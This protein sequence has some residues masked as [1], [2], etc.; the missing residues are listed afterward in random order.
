MTDWIGEAFTSDVGPSLHEEL[1]DIGNRL[2]GSEGERRGAER[3][4]EALETA[5]AREARLEAFDIQGWT[6]GSSAVA[7][8]DETFDCIALPR[9]PPGEV[10]GDLVDLGY[11][12]PEDFEAADVEGRVVVVDSN[13]PDW[14]DRFIHRREKYYYAVEG[15]ASAFLFRNHVE[16]CLAPTGSV[17]TEDAPIGDVPAVG[18][19]KEAGARLARRYEGEPVTVSVEADVH[20]A[21]SRNVHAVLGPDT[22]EEVLV[23]SHVDGHDIAEGA[24]DNGAGTAIVVQTAVALA[25]REDDLD[26][27]VHFV[28]FGSEEVGLDG[29]THYVETHDLDRVKAV[30]NNDGSGRAR[31]LRVVS[32]HF[33]ELG[34]AAERVADRLDNPVDV[35]PRLGPHSDHWP[36]VQRGVPGVQIR[37]VTGSRGRGWG[38]T[39]ADTYDKVDRRDVRTQAILVADL[40]VDVAREDVEVPRKEESEIARR[41]EEEDLAVGMK[42]IGDWPY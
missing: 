30:L 10:E 6:R 3:T 32:H 11:G 15:G 37:S 13:V 19:S 34:A 14:F 31:D 26:T 25:A 38:H 36:F 18:V 17:G 35:V 20:D 4:R 23:T 24:L 40:A 33:D 8:G 21:T 9:S 39:A 12:L 28:A 1:V 2:G 7:A 41:L 22:D 5:G 27:R 16:G 42:V 29:S